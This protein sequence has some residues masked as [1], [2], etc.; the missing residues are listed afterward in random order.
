MLFSSVTFLFYFL[1]MV[2]VLYYS[3]F[4]SISLKNMVLF[5]AS[6]F[7]YAWGEPKFVLIMLVSITVNYLFGLLVAYYKERK[8]R[9]VKMVLTFMCIY[10]LSVLFVFKYL[11]FVLRNINDYRN[12]PL[13]IPNIVLPIG[14]S[15]FTFQAMSYV[16]DVYRGTGE[17]QKNPFY[18]GLYIAFFPQLVAG[19]IV[20]YATMSDQMKKRKETWKKFSVGVCRFIVG[21][22]K[23]VLLA[24]NLAIVVDQIFAMNSSQLVDVSTAWIG[25]IA[26]TLQIYYDFSGYSDMAIGLGLLFGFKFEENFKYPYI[27][28]SI[29]EFWRRWHISLGTWFRDYVYFP[30]GGSRVANKDKMIKNLFVVWLLTGIWHGAEWTFLVWGMIHFLCIMLEKIIHVD[31]KGKG[32]FWRHLYVL[33]IVNIGWVVFR[34]AN[35]KDAGQYFIAMFGLGNT[36]I[37][38]DTAAMFLKEY[39]VFFL[40]GII[41]AYPIAKKINTKLAIGVKYGSVFKIAYP[42]VMIIGFLLCV[43]Y[44]IKGAYNPF[45][46]F[47]F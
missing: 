1:P 11:L 12:I 6:L 19:P 37:W 20:R 21:L 47:N 32:N 45:I 2:L 36:A 5:F 33:F 28:T 44:L 9:K 26:Y 40:L 22:C 25:A 14:I 31:T 15:F 34:A 27:A 8:Q 4:F 42:I 24:N 39:I 10:N 23:K 18:V 43:T 17:V 41:F 3:L 29:S 46:Y 7:F 16:I 38:S 30:M 35:L 13:S